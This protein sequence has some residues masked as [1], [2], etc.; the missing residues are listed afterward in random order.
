M[1]K[2]AFPSTHHSYPHILVSNY[3]TLKDMIEIEVE[4]NNVSLSNLHLDLVS[5]SEIYNNSVVDIKGDN[6]VIYSKYS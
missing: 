1:F 5:P 4:V 2:I 6:N 3:Y